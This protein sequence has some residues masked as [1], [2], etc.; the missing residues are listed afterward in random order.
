MCQHHFETLEATILQVCPCS[1]LVCDL[2]TS[3]EILVHTPCAC[4]FHRGETVCI[5]FNG[6]MTASIPPQISAICVARI[7]GCRRTIRCDC[8]CD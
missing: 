3:Q 2:C 8:D 6:A 7:P 1:L 4:H 5:R